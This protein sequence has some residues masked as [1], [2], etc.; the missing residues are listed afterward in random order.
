MWDQWSKLDH[1]DHPVLRDVA[2][3]WQKLI[4]R[5]GVAEHQVHRYL[6]NHGHLFFRSSCNFAAVVSKLRF[7][8]E[9][10]SDFVVV[11]D[12]RSAGITYRLVEIERPDSVPFTK[13]GI[14]SARL[15]RAIQQVLSWKQWLTDHPVESRKLFPSLL[16]QIERP[17]FEF[18]IIIGTR[19][20]TS[21]WVER[22]NALAQSLGICIRSF[23]SLTARLQNCFFDD[24]SDIHDEA[25][26]LSLEQRNQLASPFLQAM[27]DPQWRELVGK[28]P[29]S[30]S[31]V[32]SY[33][34]KL[35]PL[36][37][38]N[39]MVER[40]RRIEAGKHRRQKPR[41]THDNK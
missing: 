2:R 18:E 31:F 24:F 26:M 27:T 37:K 11:Y 5:R 19:E 7:G 30:A 28:R 16:R 21:A 40:F 15:S 13:E 8:A 22:R 1:G 12:Q 35:V 29:L 34:D 33:A 39:P 38:L 10:V 41:L 9:F 6:A 3:R 32:C 25:H 14:A 17:V 4:H 20:N 36:R 23:D